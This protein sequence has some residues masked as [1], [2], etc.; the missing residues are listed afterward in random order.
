MT[1]VARKSPKALNLFFAFTIDK[2]ELIIVRDS[3]LIN[4]QIFFAKLPFKIR[5]GKK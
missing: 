5:E 3:C 4:V 2:K 1:S